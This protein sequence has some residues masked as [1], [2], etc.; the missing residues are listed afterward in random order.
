MS[1]CDERVGLCEPYIRYGSHYRCQHSRVGSSAA[2][3]K[4]P[5]AARRAPPVFDIRLCRR[6]ILDTA[7]QPR[8]RHQTKPT[9]VLQYAPSARV[10]HPPFCVGLE[11]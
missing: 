1:M 9:T 8:L 5:A 6:H 7:S 4:G 2:L 3:V 10:T 11:T